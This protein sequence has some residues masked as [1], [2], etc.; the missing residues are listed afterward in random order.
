MME[1]QAKRELNSRL[2]ELFDAK[3]EYEAQLRRFENINRQSGPL[4]QA[5][6]RLKEAE[7]RFDANAHQI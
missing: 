7:E 1:D 3:E 6:Q 5:L 2:Q 4:L